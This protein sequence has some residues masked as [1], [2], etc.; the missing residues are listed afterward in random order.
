ML[1]NFENI[2]VSFPFKNIQMDISLPDKPLNQVIA[3]WAAISC[4]D[5]AKVTLENSGSSVNLN[6]T[7]SMFQDE[8]NSNLQKLSNFPPDSSEKIRLEGRNQNLS[9]QIQ[10]YQ[11]EIERNPIILENLDAQM[12]TPL[13][14]NVIPDVVKFI[15]EPYDISLFHIKNYNELVTQN[16]FVNGIL[17]PK[18]EV[19]AQN[20]EI[21]VPKEVFVLVRIME[22]LIR[23]VQANKIYINGVKQ[24]KFKVDNRDSKAMGAYLY[25]S[26][27]N[28]YAGML[29]KIRAT[30]TGTGL[31]WSIINTQI[32]FSCLVDSPIFNYYLNFVQTFLQ[33][34][35]DED[36]EAKFQYVAARRDISEVA[37]PIPDVSIDGMIRN[38]KDYYIDSKFFKLAPITETPE[39]GNFLQYVKNGVTILIKVDTSIIIEVVQVNYIYLRGIRAV[40]RDGSIYNG[41][42]VAAVV[43]KTITDITREVVQYSSQFRW[44]I[45]K[46]TLKNL[47]RNH[48]TIPDPILRNLGEI[49]MSGDNKFTKAVKK[50]FNRRSPST[51]NAA[52][53]AADFPDND[54]K[55]QIEDYIDNQGTPLSRQNT[56]E[57]NDVSKKKKS[58]VGG[59]K[60]NKTRKMSIKRKAKY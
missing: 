15:S 46:N 57:W 45:T 22:P 34:G 17:Q 51:A 59:R 32:L 21:R 20:I 29:N 58:A 53:A 3:E 11:L 4:L 26:V 37:S 1:P 2:Q 28:G 6:K 44:L 60:K 23:E 31:D 55:T 50:V 48:I 54:D 27:S 41:L 19:A 56:I 16:N 7:I 14:F 10:D 39:D 5:K 24:P 49:I 8:I 38:Y 43:E 12:K 47:Q 13:D 40:A 35:V 18:E 33:S 36:S 25:Y 42:I 9:K 52:A 30:Y